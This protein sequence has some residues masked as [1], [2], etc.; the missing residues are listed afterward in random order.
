MNL[1]S[2]TGF[3]YSLSLFIVSCGP[4]KE[5]VSSQARADS[6][7]VVINQL[8]SRINQLNERINQLNASLTT[9][10]AQIVQLK[11]QY[12]IV[13]QD[14]SDCKRAKQAVASRMEEFNQALAENKRSMMD[15]RNKAAD[16][17][18]R[19]SGAG[20]D[21]S[22]KNGLIYISVQDELLFNAG[23]AKP[24]KNSQEP[25]AAIAQ[26][27]N[28][29]PT[30]KIYIIGNTDSINVTR[31]FIDNWSFSTERSNSIVRVLH[32]GY[33]VQMGRI[34]SAG[35]GKYDPVADNSTVEGRKKNSRTDIVLNPDLSNLWD[36]IDKQ[37]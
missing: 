25:F 7:G 36:L 15:I 24:A 20:I 1:R 14:A 22:Y 29:N 18:H 27:L 13:M 21:V 33:Q 8:N 10:N 9:S 17:L 3:V 6:L 12:A 16:A 26:V 32:E 19:F 30:L 31:G 34:I 23:S 4:T 35:R 5:L 28:D 2:I 11:N 37:Q